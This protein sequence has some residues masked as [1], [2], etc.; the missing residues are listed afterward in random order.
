M[1]ATVF[2]DSDGCELVRLSDGLKH[3]RLQ[4]EGDSIADGP[5]HFSYCLSGTGHLNAY[6]RSLQRLSAICRLGRLPNALYP[7]DPIVVR[8]I[9]ALR[10]W[11]GAS[12][13][14]SHRDL[15]IG[16]FGKHMVTDRSFDSMRKRVSRLI[17][18]A[19]RNIHNAWQRFTAG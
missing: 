13:S 16:L 10:A 12:I 18:H 14:V 1:R 8:G 2:Q 15:A 4:L 7:T 19:N 3:F 9:M 17:S 6:A 11:D 5:V